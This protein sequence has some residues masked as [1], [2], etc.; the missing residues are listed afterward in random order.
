[1]KILEPMVKNWKKYFIEVSILLAIGLSLC[2]SA[3]RANA[4]EVVTEN[5]LK[6]E[7]EKYGAENWS[8]ILSGFNDINVLLNEEN[9]ELLQKLIENDEL[10]GKYSNVITKTVEDLQRSISTGE[11]LDDAYLENL[12]IEYANN[13]G[14]ELSQE[15]LDKLVESM[16]CIQNIDYN[17]DDLEK[18]AEQWI[19]HEDD[20]MNWLEK[21]EA[22]FMKFFGGIV[23][24]FK[25]LFGIE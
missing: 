19:E 25:N 17:F 13:Y 14:V 21:F 18:F 3:G 16:N 2:L 9:E 15:D 7:L 11:Q 20:F 12:I 10:A 24:F 5:E 23:E 8:D 1:M 22:A 6:E 4:Q